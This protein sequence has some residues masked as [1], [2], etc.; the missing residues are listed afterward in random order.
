[1]GSLWIPEAQ[2][3]PAREGGCARGAGQHMRAAV[4]HNGLRLPS[5]G[6]LS[7]SCQPCLT[8]C[9]SQMFG[10]LV[11]IWHAAQWLATGPP[12]CVRVAELGPGRGTL[13]ADFL[14]GT[15]HVSNAP[16]T[17]EGIQVLTKS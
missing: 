5:W 16:P 9:L 13:M 10:E 3:L 4:W 1:M 11:G 6:G 2:G 14:R 8:R 7:S 15:S 17:R 12:P